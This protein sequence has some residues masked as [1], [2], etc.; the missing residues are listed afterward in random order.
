MTALKFAFG[1]SQ[2][3]LLAPVDSKDSSAENTPDFMGVPAVQSDWTKFS[4]NL[5]KVLRI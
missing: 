4:T 1:S 2:H 5:G 3:L